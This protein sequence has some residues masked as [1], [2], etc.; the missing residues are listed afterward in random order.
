MTD[1]R[2]IVLT[3][4]S[5]GIGAA[6]AAELAGPDRE[7]LLVGR[8]AARLEAVGDLLRMKGTRVDTATLS[9]T[10][11]DGMARLLADYD[12]LGPVDLVIANAGISGGLSG[13][14]RPEPEGLGRAQVETNLLGVLNTVEPLL[15]PM[16]ARKAGRFVL[17]SSMAAIRPQP[18]LPSYSASKAGVRAYGIALRGWLRPLGVGVTVVCPGFVTSPMSARHGGFKPFEMSAERAARII[19]SGARRGRSSVIFP[20]PLALL[21]WGANLLPP[22][23]SE[24]LERVFAARIEP[25]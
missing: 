7:I 5:S 13:R 16:M 21:A 22:A 2:R 14:D 19:L 17:I 6:L 25:G 12:A 15:E 10:D 24:R 4:A 23:I 8:N 20:L 11:T 9:V 18:D 3:G 1:F